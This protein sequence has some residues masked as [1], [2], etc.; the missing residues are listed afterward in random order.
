MEVNKLRNINDNL[1]KKPIP[2]NNEL[3]TEHFTRKSHYKSFT[4]KKSHFNQKNAFWNLKESG[5]QI[6]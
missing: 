4:Y 2:I 6:L 5:V 3:V 1:D